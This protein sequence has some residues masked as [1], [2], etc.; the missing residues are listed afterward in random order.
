MTDLKSNIQL[1]LMSLDAVKLQ[2]NDRH[3]ELSEK[4]TQLSDSMQSS[5][6]R[7]LSEISKNKLISELA[8]SLKDKTTQTSPIMVKDLSVKEHFTS[9]CKTM[10]TCPDGPSPSTTNVPCTCGGISNTLSVQ[11]KGNP[12]VTKMKGRKTFSVTSAG[13]AKDSVTDLGMSDD[14]T[15]WKST[16]TM[17]DAAVTSAHNLQ[18]LCQDDSSMS[19][20]HDSPLKNTSLYSEKENRVIVTRS[21][22]KENSSKKP[23]PKHWRKKRTKNT[24][25]VPCRAKSKLAP[26][27]QPVIQQLANSVKATQDS[28]KL[29]SQNF[30]LP[31]LAVTSAPLRKTQKKNSLKFSLLRS[32]QIIGP[33]EIKGVSSTDQSGFAKAE[34][35]P[36]HCEAPSWDRSNPHCNKSSECEEDKMIW[37]PS[38]SP[39]QNNSLIHP[40]QKTGQKDL[41]TLFF[42]SSE[43]TD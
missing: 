6:N 29:F 34:Q 25:Q 28:F 42:D 16:I 30:G 21:K 4:L 26:G 10:S 33:S 12:G 39:F 36:G 20:L 7:I 5:E 14:Q 18:L 1:L 17:D 2:Q 23:K 22:D 8:C 19:L 15:R 32:Q 38:S 11:Q 35:E 24:T 37:F 3:L 40:T 13:N 9:Q 27:N 43:D 41:L 31:S